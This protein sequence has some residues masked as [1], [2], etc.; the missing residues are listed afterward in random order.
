MSGGSSSWGTFYFPHR[1]NSVT[2]TPGGK[3]FLGEGFQIAEVKDGE[4]RRDSGENSVH[5][6]LTQIQDINSNVEG[7]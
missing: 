4:Q 7:R 2:K 5:L 6:R 3:I 1:D